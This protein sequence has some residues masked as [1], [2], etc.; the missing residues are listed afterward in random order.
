MICVAMEIMAAQQSS[1]LC[2]LCYSFAAVTMKGVTRH[3]GA[4]HS[5]E[6]NFQVTCGV[7][8]CPRTYSNFHSYKK[9]LYTKHRDILEVEDGVIVAG[10]DSFG[11]S[12]DTDVITQ[13]ALTEPQPHQQHHKRE[14]ALFLWKAANVCKVS[15]SSLDIQ[16]GDVSILLENQMRSIQADLSAIL[17]E[18]GIEFD[19][20]LKAIFQKSN[21]ITPFHGLD[22]N[23]LRTKF[24]REN[25]G[26]LVSFK[27]GI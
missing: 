7:E 21:L 14:S 4:V 23:F 19:A 11:S 5:H 8:G 13:S 25:M 20:E 15:N 6:A 2:P 1:F 24:Y 17:L 16:I 12:S 9:H 10:S 18:K 3:I 26:L 22:S 27:A